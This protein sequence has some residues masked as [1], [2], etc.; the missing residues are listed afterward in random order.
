[1]PK[2]IRTILFG[3]VIDGRTDNSLLMTLMVLVLK[4]KSEEITVFKM[5]ILYV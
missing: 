1:M 5:I 4:V 2:I 3:R